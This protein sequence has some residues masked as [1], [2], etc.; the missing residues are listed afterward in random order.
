MESELQSNQK[1]IYTLLQ[2]QMEAVLEGERH[3]TDFSA[4]P[5]GLSRL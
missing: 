3:A 4:P 1:E 5:R 2:K